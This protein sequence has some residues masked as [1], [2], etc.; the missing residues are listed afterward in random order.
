MDDLDKQFDIQNSKIFLMVMDPLTYSKENLEVLKI[1]VNERN[2]SGLYVSTNRPY[3][4]LVKMMINNSIDATSLF[5][6]D[7]T[8]N[9]CKK[10]RFYVCVPPSS[11]TEISIAIPEALKNLQKNKRFI[12]LDSITN[13]LKYNSR[14][15]VMEFVK[16][17]VSKIRSWGMVGIF[18]AVGQSLTDKP[19][20]QISRYCDKIIVGNRAKWQT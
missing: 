4:I 19:I 11:L 5:F 14:E 1:F 15:T 8:S 7:T 18:F 3:E 13:L 10:S 2:Y 6:I 12:I 9:R 16:F 17:L 20:S